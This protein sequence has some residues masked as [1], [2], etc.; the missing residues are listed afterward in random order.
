MSYRVDA[1]DFLELMNLHQFLDNDSVKNNLEKSGFAQDN[2]SIS[3]E[4]VKEELSIVKTNYNP[5]KDLILDCY[6][7]DPFLEV[8]FN[9][10]G[11]EIYYKNSFIASDKVPAM[12]GNMIYVAPS[13]EKSEIAFQKGIEYN[14]FD[15]HLPLKMLI[16]YWGENRLLDSFLV[17]ATQNKSVGLTNNTITLNSKIVSVIQD[18]EHCCYDGLTRKIYLESKISEILAYCFEETNL[19]YTVKISKRD[20]DCINY[21]AQIIRDNINN[22]ITIKELAKKIGTN[23]T[24]L[25]SGFKSVFGTTVFGYLQELRM[26]KA[27]RFLYDSDL[28]VEEISRNCGYINISNFSNAFKNYFGVSPSALRNNANYRGYNRVEVK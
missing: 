8:H 7:S 27:R 3:E 13:D 25:K 22:P 12:T 1:S 9:L 5:V 4:R 15:I 16:D 28:S 18:I 14:T 17:Q 23:E 11:S 20:I 10:S 26:N 21:A 19:N 2:V 24:K 6:G